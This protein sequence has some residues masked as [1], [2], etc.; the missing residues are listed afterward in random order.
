MASVQAEELVS[1]DAQELKGQLS[2]ESLLELYVSGEEIASDDAF[3]ALVVRHGPMV[4]GICRSVLEQEADAEDAF[5]ATFLVLARKGASIRKPTLVRSWLHEVA[6]R[7]AVKASV[8]T[9]RVRTLERQSASMSFQR[10]EPD[11]QQ[12]EAVSNELRPVLHEEVDRLPEKY[13]LPIILGYLEGKTNEEVAELLHLPVGTVKGRLSRARAL[14]RSRL[15]RRGMAISA[16]FVVTAIS[17]GAVFAEVVPVELVNRTLRFVRKF[18]PRLAPPAP[19]STSSQPSTDPGIPTQ[20]EIL[21][22]IDREHPK[23]VRLPFLV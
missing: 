9:V 18:S 5:Q 1:H 6:Y 3:R 19:S 12:E 23:F 15:I 21:A 7:T 10:Y 13:R 8:D 2:D 16:A 17:D 20:V 14:L 11:Q 4:L 22:D